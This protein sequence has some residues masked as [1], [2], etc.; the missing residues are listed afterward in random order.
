[1]YV[2]LLMTLALAVPV[3]LTRAADDS[4]VPWQ[5]A[6]F[7]TVMPAPYGRL[8]LQ[9]KMEPDGRLT[10]VS[11]VREGG[12]PL[13]VPPIA[14]ANVTQ[15][16][17]GL[18]RTVF[19]SGFDGTPWMFVHIPYGNPVSVF[20]HR[21]WTVLVIAFRGERAVYRALNIPKPGGG[22]EWQPTDLPRE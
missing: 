11:L 4:F 10:D 14:W 5:E 18:V 22:Y 16:Q 19:K 8:Q 12:A 15:T 21:E 1:M 17:L 7:T 20:G 3:S 9:L 13:H 6:S 2:P